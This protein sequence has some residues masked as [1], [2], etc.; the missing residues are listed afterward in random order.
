MNTLNL[1]PGNKKIMQNKGCLSYKTMLGYTSK[2]RK[3]NDN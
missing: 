2:I 3:L 1:L